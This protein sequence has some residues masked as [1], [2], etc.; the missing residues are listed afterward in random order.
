MV[1][2]LSEQE[3]N[4]FGGSASAERFGHDHHSIFDAIH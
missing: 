3:K 1:G 4:E 2:S